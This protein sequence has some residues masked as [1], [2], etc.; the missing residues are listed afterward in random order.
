MKRVSLVG[1]R[2]SIV[3]AA[4]QVAVVFA[5]AVAAAA[6][7]CASS[8]TPKPAA[9]DPEVWPTPDTLRPEPAAASPGATPTPTPA[10]IDD[11]AETHF[12]VTV[13][14]PYRW[15]ERGGPALEAFLAEQNGYARRTLLAIP[16]RDALRD[17][18]REANRGVTRVS[19]VGV[20]G[21]LAAPRIFTMK[22][23]PDEL[24]AQLYVR[25][26]WSGAD[27]LLVDPRTRDRDATHFSIDYAEP[28]PDGQHVAYGISAAG[29]EDSVIEISKVDSGEVLAERIDRAQYASIDW[30][31]NQSFFY[32]RR[33]APAAGDSRADWFKNSATYLHVLGGDPGGEQPVITPMM[34]EL[35]LAPEMFTWIDVTPRSPWV[36]ANA[37]PGTSADWQYFTAPLAAV[38]AG[39][40]PWRRLSGPTDHVTTM[41]AHG[42]TI[43]AL[44]Y[45]GA[46][47]FRVLTFSARTGSLAK[48]K[49][50]V[51]EREAVLRG[52]YPAADALYLL[53]FDGGKNRVERIGYDGKGRKEIA[54]P[55]PGTAYLQTEAE[56]PGFV[57][58][59]E[60]WAR[61]PEDFRY[62][63]KGGMQALALREPWPIDYSNIATELVEI[64][65][66]DGAKVPMSIIR[67]KDTPLDGSAPALLAGYQAYGGTDQPF[68]STLPLTWVT[69]GGVRANCHGRGTGNR[70]KQWHLDGI[71]QHKERG[72]DDFLACAEYLIARKYTTAAR[73]TVTGTSAGGILA[74]GAITKRPELF[75]AA[76]LRVPTVNLLRF[77]RTEGGPANVP[78]FGTIADE[79]GFKAMLAS[80]PHHRLVDGGK[81]PAM[82]VTGGVHDVRVPIWMPAKFVARAQAATGNARPILF[83]VE[84][85][86]HGRGTTNAQL[87][88]EWADLYAFALWQ[89]GLAIAK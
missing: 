71:K 72:V 82:V 39:K 34:K 40:T 46:P 44:S 32:W 56:R 89:S 30:R 74:G 22:R 58:T 15:M 37:T 26:G 9:P 66:S 87:E 11:V 13:R 29:S 27:R 50:F 14:D 61:A 55:F 81:V 85:A 83:R 18:L 42:D 88:E 23:G 43:Y 45:A 63:G 38:A 57:L 41:V 19:V 75:A 12:G 67:R 33:R 48:A 78:E 20:R 7:G 3:T 64:P 17:A 86:G 36:L 62:D 47:R 60:S 70:G 84:S 28:S 52:L 65:T 25:E 1:A 24:T 6:A 69:R 2:L 79:Q 77:E 5:V 80:D 35:G 4:L 54:L 16:G 51:P 53:Y 8:A 73:L 59:A 68:F 49:V 76:F 31:D 21:A 10:K